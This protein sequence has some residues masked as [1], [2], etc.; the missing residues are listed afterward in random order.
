MRNWFLLDWWEQTD[1]LHHQL[2]SS[3]LNDP[4]MITAETDKSLIA[5]VHEL[6]VVSFESEAWI[7]SVLSTSPDENFEKYLSTRFG[8]RY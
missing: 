7:N 8:A 5:C 6:R 2:F 3:P 4:N 1:I